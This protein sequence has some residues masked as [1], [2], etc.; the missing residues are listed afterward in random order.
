MNN[1]FAAA[2]RLAGLAAMAIV[3]TGA[4]WGLGSGI[5]QADTKH[6]L[7][8]PHPI[9]FQHHPFE[10]SLLDRILDHFFNDDRKK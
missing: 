5:A 10:G 6:P 4:G 2:K 3:V 9:L 1:R 7:P 8:P